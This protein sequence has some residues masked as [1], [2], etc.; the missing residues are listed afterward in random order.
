MDM[1]PVPFAL[2]VCLL[3]CAFAATAP[4]LEQ[5]LAQAIR[6]FP[7]KVA[8]YA[9]NLDT[10]A[11]IGVLP[12]EQVRTASTIKLPIMIA[13]F[14]EVEAGRLSWTE[15]FTL[16]AEDKVGGSGVVR[17]L[18]NGVKL[19]LRDLV[20]LMIVVSDNTATNLVLERVGADTVNRYLDELGFPRTRSIRKILNGPPSGW[21]QYGK[22][23]A[24]QRFGI[25]VSTPR[26]MV[27]LLEKLE[28]GDVVS[29][30][31]SKEM[32]E[33]LRRQQYTDGIGRRLGDTKAASKSGALDALRS[34]VGVVYTKR[35]RIAIAITCDGMR[36]G[37]Y[38]ADNPGLLMIA[39]LT[40]LLLE[41]LA[42]PRS[43][44]R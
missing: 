10:G 30:A 23:E 41:G 37:Y 17:E 4:P 18:S 22:V 1:R 35:G 13:V 28:K 7:G 25:G 21:S 33:I 20:H 27:G 43:N 40:E 26:D 8:L 15:E 32:I 19:P 12:N 3:P 31:A 24:N 29:P 6:K 34:D 44:S 38:S 5:R 9:R 14:G 16:R 39:Q 2:L 11:E 36:G 42:T